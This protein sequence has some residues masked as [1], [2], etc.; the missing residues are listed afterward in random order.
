MNTSQTLPGR[1][2]NLLPGA[3]VLGKLALYFSLVIGMMP[4]TGHTQQS[5]VSVDPVVT[6]EFTQTVPILGRLVA[7]QTGTVATRIAGPVDEIL[8]QVGDR[9]TEGQLLAV[10][11]SET[12]GLQ[13][14]LAEMQRA[15]AQTRITTAKAQLELAMQEVKRLSGLESSASVSKASMEDA[16]QQR[17]IAFAR[18]GEAEAAVSSSTAAIRLADLELQHASILAPFDGT[19]T[20]KLT[21]EGSYLQLGASVVQL[22][23]D[24]LLELEADIPRERLAGL[25]PGREINIV[26]DGDGTHTARVRAI[27][28]EENPRTRTRRVRFNV[29]LD[30]R[31]Q[32]LAVDQSVVLHIPA[33]ASRQVLS[34]HKDGIIRNSSG[35]VVYVVDQDVAKL[36]PIHTGESVGNRMEVL[37]GLTAGEKVVV[38]GNERLQPDQ[39]VTIADGA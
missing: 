28:P 22:V 9:V 23:S 18:V 15:E 30:P 11:D 24:N 20:A 34:V 26:L 13:K 5:L 6:Q 7:R 14:E 3:G 31:Q 4:M 33:G 35:A 1:V 19:V 38:R 39:P 10:L 21:E 17:N 37:D 16:V 32:A 8:V 36:R 27:V 12:L 29:E 2:R 25:S